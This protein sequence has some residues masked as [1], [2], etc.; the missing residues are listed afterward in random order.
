MLIWN[1][2]NT[3]VRN[4][5]RLREALALFQKHMSGR[6]FTKL[7][8]V[9]FQG[10]MIDEGLVDSD[11]RG[12]DD[13][14]RKFASAFKQL[15]FV[16]DWARGSSWTITAVGENLIK[17]PTIEQTIFLRQLL[18]Y[19]IP[20]PLERTA[21]LDVRPFRLL[22]RF[23]QRAHDEGMTGLTKHEIGLFV[24]T[25]L[26]E[27]ATT[28][29]TAFV[30]IRAF[31][32]AYDAYHGR[33]NKMRFAGVEAYKIAL[34]LGLAPGT[35]LDYADSSSR[36]AL[37]SGLLTIRGNKLAV[38]A[39]RLPYIMEIL[40]DGSALLPNANYLHF[41]YNP[42]FPL[43]PTDDPTFLNAE[44]PQLLAQLHQVAD[45]IRE[46]VHLTPP[47]ADMS[48]SELQD[49]EQR[50]RAE[51]KRVKEIQFY[52]VQST[53][54]A[55]EEIE[56]MLEE[57]RDGTLYGGQAYAPAFFEW[58][59]WRLFLAINHI[60]GEIGKTR[61]FNIDED[62]QPIH[63]ARGGAADLTFHYKDFIIVCEMT[64]ATGSRQF[65]M[66][67]EPVTRHVFKAVN[68]NPSLPVYGMFFAKTI[69]PNTA[70]AFHNARYW[71]DWNTP[72]A[73]PVI[74][75]DMEQTLGFVRRLRQQ[76]ITLEVLHNLLDSILADQAEHLSGPEWYRSYS[77]S[78]VAPFL[79]AP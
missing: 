70:D 69:D 36:Y 11:R 37:M 51:I 65:T 56:E 42:E 26:T 20:S 10:H 61:G 34:R 50:L 31:R 29:E 66:E 14:A 16:T 45:T 41:Y 27:D 21:G 19:Q 4:P 73:T 15:G 12:G 47:R 2:G 53:D 24:D 78:V 22:L 44:I 35:L 60:E 75:L 30:E 33:V 68:A 67:G 48:L 7:E 38:S 13:G 18:K 57:I 1:I 64:L 17:H 8:Q 49:Y 74:A 52:R 71:Q 46:T 55:L 77:A 23:L 9:E 3:T 43:L 62:L 76:P 72:V 58:S 63:H 6:P 39:A 28:F 54:M 40:A 25:V 32:N 79:H 5:E 59:I